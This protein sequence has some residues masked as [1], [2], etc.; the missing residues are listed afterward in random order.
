MNALLGAT[1]QIQTV[2]IK[3]FRS[4]CSTFS[5]ASF[6]WFCTSNTYSSPILAP[7]NARP[8]P[9]CYC[10][11]RFWKNFRVSFA[12]FSTSCTWPSQLSIRTHRPCFGSDKGTCYPDSRR[13]CEVRAIL[14]DIMHCE[15]K[16]IE[17]FNFEPLILSYINFM[18]LCVGNIHWTTTYEYSISIWL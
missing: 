9:S 12:C 1:I 17:L 18:S 11:D 4:Q 10:K 2:L 5:A 7:R 14:K 3:I 13:G 8:G 15:W 6:S 16:Q